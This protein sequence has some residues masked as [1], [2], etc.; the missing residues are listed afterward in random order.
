MV[1]FLA[2]PPDLPVNRASHPQC[3]PV[4]V[5][6]F[7][8]RKLLC[9]VCVSL[10]NPQPHTLISL[11]FFLSASRKRIAGHFPEL[12]FFAHRHQPS[13]LVIIIHNN[14]NI[15]MMEGLNT[16]T[17]NNNIIIMVVIAITRVYKWGGLAPPGRVVGF[18][19]Y[20]AQEPPYRKRPYRTLF[21][22]LTKTPNNPAHP[23]PLNPKPLNPDP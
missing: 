3:L 19:A 20:D 4:E 5:G 11:S 2:A 22:A 23:N 6:V 10:L 18:S 15:I 7:G 1:R 21:E 17:P 13:K 8:C 14:N 16:K 12:A 9:H